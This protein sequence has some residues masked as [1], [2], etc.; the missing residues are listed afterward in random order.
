MPRYKLRTLLA[1]MVAFAVAFGLLRG[2][3]AEPEPYWG[4]YLIGLTSVCSCIAAL[5]I[6]SFDPPRLSD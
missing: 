6:V 2:V 5:V 4:F 3:I 1:L